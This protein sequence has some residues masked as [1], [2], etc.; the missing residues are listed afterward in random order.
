MNALFVAFGIDLPL[1]GTVFATRTVVVSLIVGTTITVLA[2]I[3]PALRAT[4]VPPISAV[5]EGSTP[6]K[7]RF[8]PIAPYVALGTIAV[9]VVALGVGL[10]VNGLG[11]KGVLLLL[12]LGTIALFIGFALRR[13]APRE[14]AGRRRRLAGRALRR[15]G[16]RARPRELD[17]QPRPDRLDRGGTHDR[18]RARDGRGR[19]RRGASRLDAGRGSRPGGG[20]VRRDV[21]E[22]LRPDPRGSGRGR[23]S[24]SGGRARVERPLRPG[25]R[26]H[27][28]GRG[29]RRR[30]ADDRDLLR[31]RVDRG[32]RRDARC[33]GDRRCG[34][35]G[36]VRRGSRPHGRQS[37]PGRDREWEVRRARRSRN[38]RS[39]RPGGAPR[40]GHDEPGD[41]RRQLPATARPLHVRQQQR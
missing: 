3:V 31:V 26:R 32:L 24:C 5:R 17:P 27:E 41:V 22:R 23:R 16:G 29:H 30:P 10:F 35:D 36:D 34:R 37:V 40:P 25:A 19:A 9:A 6:P 13:S 12:G 7:S 1:A 33:T 11:T 15:H 8:A 18:A 20:R 28:R 38:L 4:R 14:A 21:A 39:V 2:S